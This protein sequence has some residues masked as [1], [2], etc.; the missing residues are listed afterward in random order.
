MFAEIRCF[1][2]EAM[3]GS[4]HCDLICDYRKRIQI[5]H[6]FLMFFDSPWFLGGCKYDTSWW[7][8]TELFHQAFKVSDFP[9]LPS[10]VDTTDVKT[11]RLPTTRRWCS[12]FRLFVVVVLPCIFARP[13]S[14]TIGP[15]GTCAVLDRERWSEKWS[16]QST[17]LRG[18]DHEFQVWWIFFAFISAKSTC[19]GDMA[20][21]KQLRHVEGALTLRT[22]VPCRI[23]LL[24]DGGAQSARVRNESLR[25]RIL[26]DWLQGTFTGDDPSKDPASFKHWLARKCS[27]W[28][29][30]GEPPK[31]CATITWVVSG[32]SAVPGR[33]GWPN[34]SESIP[35]EKPAVADMKPL[36]KYFFVPTWSGC[37]FAENNSLSCQS[38]FDAKPKLM[39]T[40]L[41]EVFVAFHVPWWKCSEPKWQ[42]SV[43]MHERRCCK[44]LPLEAA[45]V[46][47]LRTCGRAT[48][49]SLEAGRSV[50]WKDPFCL[51]LASVGLF[52]SW[53]GCA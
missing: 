32:R 24:W 19:A 39:L 51:R 46:L 30:S 41:P 13:F 48:F 25:G 22:V 34:A 4:W 37:R 7:R 26:T 49:I 8:A 12:D 42:S 35:C 45:D 38:A 2:V 17:L 3:H 36:G 9:S 10:Q 50:G 31:E 52:V 43:S 47:C 5:N 14:A 21:R 53:D 33:P 44:F 27:N 40:C 29:M 15:L 11:E 20:P 1:C 28:C 23:L 16:R 18:T 6:R